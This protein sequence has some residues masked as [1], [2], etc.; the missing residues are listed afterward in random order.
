MEREIKAV[1]FT[2]HAHERLR[3]RRITQKM[4]VQAIQQPDRTEKED[5]GDT[6]F[7]KTIN[8]RALQ[9]IGHW[10]TDENKWLVKSAW[11]RG[12]EDT[13]PSVIGQMIALIQRILSGRRR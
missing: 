1:I 3:Q 8:G 6:K 5:D 11:V 4:V 10:E 7:T 13:P 9:V 12:E 2:N